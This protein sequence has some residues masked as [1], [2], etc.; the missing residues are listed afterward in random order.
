MPCCLIQIHPVALDHFAACV[1]SWPSTWSCNQNQMMLLHHW[2]G[3]RDLDI[4]YEWK[5]H[6]SL[7]VFFWEHWSRNYATG[8]RCPASDVLDW[9]SA[10]TV[11]QSTRQSWCCVDRYTDI[12]LHQTTHDIPQSCRQLEDLSQDVDLC[13]NDWYSCRLH[14]CQILWYPWHPSLAHLKTPGNLVIFPITCHA[15]V[16]ED[17]HRYSITGGLTGHGIEW[18]RLIDRNLTHECSWV[19]LPLC[20]FGV[21]LV[22]VLASGNYRGLSG[23]GW[24]CSQFMW[25]GI[26]RQCCN[27]GSQC[28]WSRQCIIFVHFV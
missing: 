5:C 16:G 19:Y 17:V 3:L 18:H 11:Q 13:L 22:L 2:Y 8:C 12:F 7:L 28:S 23:W 27:H 21:F 24:L 25:S 15:P 14:C 9:D 6:Q 10:H 26:L 1:W 4:Y 20:S